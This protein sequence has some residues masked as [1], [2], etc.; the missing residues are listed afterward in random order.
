MTYI[1]QHT[2]SP[3]GW[4]VSLRSGRCWNTTLF[5]FSQISRKTW[6]VSKNVLIQ[7]LKLTTFPTSSKTIYFCTITWYCFYT[8]LCVRCYFLGHVDFSGRNLQKQ[9]GISLGENFV[10]FKLHVYTFC[11]TTHTSWHLISENQKQSFSETSNSYI[12]PPTLQDI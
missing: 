2:K 1:V 8:I 5:G 11:Y 7:N 4:G 12:S 9:N 3:V 6:V 10:S